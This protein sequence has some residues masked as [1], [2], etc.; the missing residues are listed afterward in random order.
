MER[1]ATY[2]ESEAGFTL[3]ELLIVLAISSL[4]VAALMTLAF[5]PRPAIEVRAAQSTLIATL[6]DARA[7]AISLNRPVN[8]NLNVNARQIGIEGSAPISLG[9]DDL[10]VEFTTARKLTVGEGEGALIFFPDGSSTGGRV[11][12]NRGGAS[13]SLDIDWLTGRVH[14]I[15]AEAADGAR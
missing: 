1:I 7:Q 12:L 10:A 8:V 5:G 15:E 13:A 2:R 14:Q 11:T 4:V 6:R 9:S 3:F